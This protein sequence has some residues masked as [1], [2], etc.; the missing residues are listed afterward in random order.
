M[1]T[2]EGA[3]GSIYASG[4]GHFHKIQWPVGLDRV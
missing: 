1:T 2:E 3:G 4:L